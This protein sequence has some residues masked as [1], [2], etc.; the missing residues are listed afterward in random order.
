[1]SHGEFTVVAELQ[2]PHS[3]VPVFRFLPL[4]IRPGHEASFEEELEPHL[5]QELLVLPPWSARAQSELKFAAAGTSRIGPG[6]F[7][8]FGQN[9]QIKRVPH[10]ESGPGDE[11]VQDGFHEWDKASP[12][13]FNQ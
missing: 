4:P 5:K 13:R 1:M 3:V 11:R 9:S 8:N 7:A 6:S 2:V 10:P 12:F